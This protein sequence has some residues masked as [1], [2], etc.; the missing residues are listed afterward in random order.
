MKSV[1]FCKLGIKLLPKSLVSLCSVLSPPEPCGAGISLRFMIRS[2]NYGYSRF[3]HLNK[4][5]GN[6]L[7]SQHYILVFLCSLDNGIF[8]AECIV[9]FI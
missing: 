6:I 8:N 1:G 3:L 9:G 2:E 4:L 7:N 5:L